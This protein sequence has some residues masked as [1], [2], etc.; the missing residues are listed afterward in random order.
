MFFRPTPDDA[1]LIAYHVGQVLLGLGLLH[2][3]PLILAVG[4][5]EWNAASALGI[6]AGAT[7]VAAQL[8]MW[9]YPAGTRLEWA[10][11]LVIVAV[12][13]LAGALFAAIPLYL[14]GHVANLLD[15]VFE[16]MSGLTTSGLS[17]TQDLD[18]LPLSINLW[19]HLLHFVGGQGIVVVVIS[20]LAVAGTQVGIL[21]VGEGREERIAPN[22]VRTARFIYRV[23]G[24]YLLFGTVAITAATLE[25]GLAPERA[26][27]HGV[28]LF[29]AAFDT[30]G[31]APQSTSIAYYHSALVEVVLLLFMIA[32]ALSFGLHYRLWRR[33]PGELLRHLE[34]HVLAAS[35]LVITTVALVGLASSG[36]LDTPTG[37]FRKGVFTVLSAHTGTGF[38]VTHPRLFVTD[39][40]ALAPAAIVAAM[41][42]GGM[43]SSTAG[44]IKAA[45]VGIVALGLRRDIARV[46][47]PPAALTV[48]TYHSGRRQLVTDEQVRSAGMILL[49][50][51]LSYI[52]GGLT[53]L[54]YGHDFTASFFESTS[55]AANVGLSVGITAPGMPAPLEIV[56]LVQMWL[57][58]LEFLTAFALL[59]FVVSIARGRV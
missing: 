16:A 35:T 37:L 34:T 21:Y 3:L 24:V 30:G 56:Y 15:A 31:F 26:L 10:H 49:L 11:G 33:R 39:W 53:G 59:A 51:L 7:L 43:A 18:H 52:A 42:L 2:V 47:G 23:A 12:A 9:R 17:L 41:A 54:F 20:V 57:G 25:A 40:G 48:A 38:A 27:F 46:V 44:G 22:V 29:M 13:W 8:A 58:R 36:P 55:A 4:N 32:G 28:T 6:G 1:S 19:R 50:Y 45:R 14:S 5:A